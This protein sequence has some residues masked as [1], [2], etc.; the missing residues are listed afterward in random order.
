MR[1]KS[2]SQMVGKTIKKTVN[3]PLEWYKHDVK[4]Y[5]IIVFEDNY[6]IVINSETDYSDIN[7][8]IEVLSDCYK[9]VYEEIEKLIAGTES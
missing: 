7:T 4:D 6:Y 9:E 3:V 5:L 2:I 8:Q 1:L